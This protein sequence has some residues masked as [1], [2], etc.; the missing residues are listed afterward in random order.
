MKKVFPCIF[1]LVFLLTGCSY[2]V[3]PEVGITETMEFSDGYIFRST[4]TKLYGILSCDSDAPD[5][6]Q[7]KLTGEIR[8]VW[9]SYYEINVADGR[10]TREKYASY[11]DSLCKKFISYGITDAFVQVR[12]YADALYE[13]SIYPTSVY[14][15]VRQGEKLKFDP[16]EVICQ[17][18]SAYGVRVH[19]WVNPYRVH[20][21]ADINELSSDNKA[22]Q[23]YSEDSS[24]DVAVV[25]GKIYFNPASQKA[26]QLIVD[27]AKEILENYPVAGIH[28]DDYFYPPDCGDFDLQQY[29]DYLSSS[30]TLSLED[31]RRENVN[32]LV[33][34]V[35]KTVKSVSQDKIFSISP[36]G[37]IS[38]NY[39]NLYADVALWC[40]G[41]YA[42]MII[43]QIYF[44]FEHSTQ[45]FDKCTAN[46]Y[47]LKGENVIM[48]VGLGVYKSGTE[49]SFAGEGS[50]EWQQN[51]DIITRQVEHIRNTGGDGFVIFSVR[52]FTDGSQSV[53]KEM[54]N[55]KNYLD[56]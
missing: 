15:G 19:A 54:D 36:A 38:N 13:S 23:W 8:G 56:S 21:T 45:P 51:N 6:N 18:M 40:G 28:I 14:A 22:R 41:G 39:N 46:W 10:D 31:W 24:D 35:Y 1:L 9:L 50:C 27:G 25:G 43:P 12:P 17:I 52:F 44:G 3:L 33:L 16:L 11:M 34:S 26:R 42:D 5:E 29:S 20:N 48:P 47:A 4:T 55:L 37:N 32:K 53:K 7:K 49:D 30:G 2:K